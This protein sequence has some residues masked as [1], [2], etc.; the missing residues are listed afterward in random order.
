[1]DK[2]FYDSTRRPLGI[3]RIKTLLCNSRFIDIYFLFYVPVLLDSAMKPRSVSA[4]ERYII[5]LWDNWNHRDKGTISVAC[6]HQTVMT[7]WEQILSIQRSL[8]KDIWPRDIQL[9]VSSP[10]AVDSER[11]FAR[12]SSTVREYH[13]CACKC[14]I[15]NIWLCPSLITGQ[16]PYLSHHCYNDLQRMTFCAWYY[17]IIHIEKMT[18]LERCFVR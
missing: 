17:Y 18:D 15:A 13:M 3:Y 16:T 1:M 2:F 11:K 7:I 8:Y 6:Q 14:S 4:E 5:I 9:D 12:I 10:P